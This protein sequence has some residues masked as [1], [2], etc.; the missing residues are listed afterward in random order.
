LKFLDEIED[1]YVSPIVPT[2][3]REFICRF[4]CFSLNLCRVRFNLRFFCIS[5]KFESFLCL[6]HRTDVSDGIM[7]MERLA[8]REQDCPPSISALAE[9]KKHALRHRVWFRLLNRV[10][11]GVIDLTVRYVDSIKSVKLAK[12]LTAIMEKL[13]FALERI[14]DRLVR[15]VGLPLARKISNTAIN[16]GYRL[17]SMW[18]EDIAFA[19]FL[20]VNHAET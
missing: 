17:A 10:E 2:C 11:R 18:A 16:W 20:V 14:V 3:F 12:V 5:R 19:R 13:Q 15:T 6:S 1:Y 9:A 7:G 8:R 4:N